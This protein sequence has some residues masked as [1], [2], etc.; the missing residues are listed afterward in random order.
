VVDETI[1]GYPRKK[2]KFDPEL[3]DGLEIVD[4][5]NDD[6]DDQNDPALVVVDEYNKPSRDYKQL[7]KDCI[8]DGQNL[9]QT[10]KRKKDS[11]I[12]AHN[13][14]LR[15]KISELRN[16]YDQKIANLKTRHDKQMKDLEDIKD[17]ACNDEVTKLRQEIAALEIEV[18]RQKDAIKGFVEEN[19]ELD[20]KLNRE[21]D[22]I[23]KQC[24]GRIKTLND[25][26]KSLQ[27]DS[28]ADM[29]PLIK[30]IYNCTTME[31]IFTIQKLVENHQLDE[32]VDKHLPTLQNLLFSLSYGIL[33]ICQ[34]QRDKVSD[35]QRKLVDNI[36]N[37]SNN[38]AKKLIRNNKRE[39]VNL[40]SII[41]DSIKLARNSYNKFN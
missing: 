23:E 14:Q 10:Y 37:S 40:F 19:V 13:I 8:D 26:I 38:G 18:R 11:L 25:H 33:P 17:A 20:K 4:E 31:E 28:S 21:K 3:D 30:A 32:V 5:I 16:Q 12:A 29:N 2:Q 24:A 9:K 15:D 22:E 35:E 6:S 27:E 1:D 36:Q 7:Y 34:P 39:I 41:K